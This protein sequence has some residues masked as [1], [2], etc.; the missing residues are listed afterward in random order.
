[1]DWEWGTGLKSGRL[2]QCAWSYYSE[3][4]YIIVFVYM[5]PNGDRTE[6]FM[7]IITILR[8]VLGG[9]VMLGGVRGNGMYFFTYVISNLTAL[10]LGVT[11]PVKPRRNRGDITSAIFCKPC[12][13]LNALS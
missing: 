8:K 4:L 1:M 9:G 2:M 10:F 12:I 13:H 7:C 5:S 3:W 11:F 6:A